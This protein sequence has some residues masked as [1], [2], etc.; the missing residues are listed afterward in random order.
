MKKKTKVTKKQ[1]S[2]FFYLFIY[3]FLLLLLL[4]WIL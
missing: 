1:I 3:L 2:L 4:F